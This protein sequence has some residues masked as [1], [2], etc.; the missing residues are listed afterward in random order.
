MTPE[1]ML[2]KSVAFLQALEKH[3]GL[4]ISPDIPAKPALKNAPQNELPD[5]PQETSSAPPTR[6]ARRRPEDPQN[7]RLAHILNRKRR[8]AY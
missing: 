3:L 5:A 8:D 7:S 1:E 2:R 4:P 6:K